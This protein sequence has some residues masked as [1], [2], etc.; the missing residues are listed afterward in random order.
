MGFTQENAYRPTFPTFYEGYSSGS[1][2]VPGSTVNLAGA[3]QIIGIGVN[4]REY[5]QYTVAQDAVQKARQE[6]LASQ[7]A[8]PIITLGVISGKA[9]KPKRTVGPFIVL[10][11]A[12]LFLFLA[13]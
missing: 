12:V 8:T 4:Q 5:A 3:N 1:K 6:Q 9:E 7:D 2:I 13:R 10:G 11:L